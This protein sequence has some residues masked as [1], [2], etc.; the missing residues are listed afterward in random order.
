MHRLMWAAP[1]FGGLTAAL[2][3][4][5]PGAADGPKADLRPSASLPITR[6]VLFNSG[7]AYFVRSGQVTDEARVDLAFPEADVNDLIK[8]M[9]LVDPSAR[10]GWPP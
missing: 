2:L 4:A 9:T 3:L 1:A 7:V 10:A 6:V 8:S 5:G